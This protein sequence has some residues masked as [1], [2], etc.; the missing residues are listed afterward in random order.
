MIRRLLSCLYDHLDSI[1]L[2]RRVQALH[3]LAADLE[4]A[5]EQTERARAEYVRRAER[6]EE[7]KDRLTARVK[8][9]KAVVEA[10]TA[11]FLRYENALQNIVSG[12]PYDP[13]G[14]ARKALFSQEEST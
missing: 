7:E 10:H 11:R 9:L 2:A 4:N 3:A 5:L 8:E 12:H 1:E 14:I 13:E 6:A